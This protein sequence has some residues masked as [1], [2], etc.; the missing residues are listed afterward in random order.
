MSGVCPPCLYPP[1]VTKVGPQPESVSDALGIRAPVLLFRAF[2]LLT[3]MQNCCLSQSEVVLGSW[4][5]VPS[6]YPVWALYLCRALSTWTVACLPPT[7]DGHLSTAVKTLSC[8][9]LAT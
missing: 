2:T 3:N 4:L 7:W 6:M 8:H 5:E 9:S 1:T